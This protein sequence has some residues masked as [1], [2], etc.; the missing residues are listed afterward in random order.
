MQERE[1]AVV[2]LGMFDGVHIGHQLLLRRARELAQRERC[3]AVA[4][5]FSN[6]PVEVLGG[7]RLTLLTTFSEREK[8]ILAA[9]VDE[10]CAVPFTKEFASLSPSAFFDALTARF[11]L[12]GVVAGFNYTFGKH[13]AGNAATLRA[14][15]RERGFLVRVMQPVLFRGRPV[16]SS[17]IRRCIENGAVRA[18][19]RMLGRPY[20]VSGTVVPNLQNGRRL[21][22]PTANLLPDPARACPVAGVYA[23]RAS[24]DGTTY[25]AV[26]NV[27]TNPTLHGRRLMIETHLLDFDRDLYG[28]TLTVDFIARIRGEKTFGSEEALAKRVLRDIAAAKRLLI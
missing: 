24:V 9:G 19:A 6:H 15:G 10:V 18:A 12:V 21:G 28:E 13:G 17:R 20:R 11:T 8:L 26:T 3:R 27:G 14:I 7:G 23:A 4:F 1:R 16:S 2:A 22:F 25:R 5:T